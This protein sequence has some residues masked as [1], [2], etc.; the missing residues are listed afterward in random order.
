MFVNGTCPPNGIQ[1]KTTDYPGTYP[2]GLAGAR[3]KAKLG[4]RVNL[5]DWA[6]EIGASISAEEV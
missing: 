4:L 2:A 1:L 5:A 3:N 6:E